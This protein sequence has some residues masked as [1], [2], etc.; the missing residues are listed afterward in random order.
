MTFWWIISYWII[1]LLLY[2]LLCPIVYVLLLHDHCFYHFFVY[3]CYCSPFCQS[4]KIPYIF[5]TSFLIFYLI[6]YLL[7]LLYW[8]KVYFLDQIVLLSL[9]WQWNIRRS[10]LF[11][12]GFQVPQC[13]LVWYKLIKLQHLPTFCFHLDSAQWNPDDVE[14]VHKSEEKPYLSISLLFSFLRLQ[15]IIRW[16]NLDVK[17]WT[18]LFNIT[19]SM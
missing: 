8:L 3:Y 18:A 6:L 15:I 10:E 5:F 11:Q 2:W 12:M 13:G 17:L 14:I 16:L 4:Y 9:I 7:Y 1:I 19:S